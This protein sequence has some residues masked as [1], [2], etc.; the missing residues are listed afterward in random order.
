MVLQIPFLFL[1]GRF[2]YHFLFSRFLL[3]DD[4][5]YLMMS[6]R[7]LLQGERIYDNVPI[8]YGPAFFFYKWLVH[9]LLQ[10]PL[11][12]DAVRLQ[13]LAVWLAS[14]L[15]VGLFVVLV[16]R[17]IALA[18][19]AQL[20]ALGALAALSNEPGHPQELVA[21]LVVL[22]LLLSVAHRRWPRLTM[23]LL[24]AVAAV[25]LCLKVNLGIFV[26]AALGAAV[27]AKACPTRFF[28]TLRAGAIFLI[29]ILP[30]LL[31][32]NDWAQPWAARY[33][34]LVS[35]SAVP[36]ALILWRDR[37]GQAGWP[38]L[39]AIG[40]GFAAT[41]GAFLLFA[42][43]RGS[44]AAAIFECLWVMPQRL[45]SFNTPLPIG[46]RST[47]GALASAA[48]GLVLTSRL[49]D[50]LANV[51]LLVLKVGLAVLVLL[52]SSLLFLLEFATPW[53]W[54]ALVPLRDER[55]ASADFPRTLA[56]TTTLLLTLWAYPIPGTQ[57]SLSTFLLAVPAAIAGG[58]VLEWARSFAPR[59]LDR[60]IVK[61]AGL[62]AV[63]LLAGGQVARLMS[64]ATVSHATGSP[65]DLPGATRLRLHP[66]L[67]AV[68]TALARDLRAAPDTFLCTDGFYSMYFWTAKD[69]PTRILIGHTIDLYTPQQMDAVAE[70][71][72]A[73]PQALLLLS[74]SFPQL[75]KPFY[76][77]LLGFFEVQQRIGPF[78]I[79][80]RAGG[81]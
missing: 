54:L 35:L 2:A 53:V 56:V 18:L 59:F 46:V 9:G 58:D 24:G 4:E 69:P 29:L 42:L 19:A 47:A 10:V 11:T 68:L 70:A 57:I 23:F 71:L 8:L 50:R 65:L 51:C 37:S 13:T 66:R 1:S 44:S 22:F 61:A 40:A 72:L 33:A 30:W 73:R 21:L 81:R 38:Q 32:K 6:V 27:L 77:N 80:K 49:P 64:F 15:G 34:G 48:V 39:S 36:I 26:L 75:Q 17:S 41:C 12:H 45:V 74:P 25:V 31:M 7:Y 78:V 16:A 76:R 3:H 60:P 14:V 55:R 62:L 43:Q 5:G 67:A 63:L 20:V 52:P 28:L 79:M